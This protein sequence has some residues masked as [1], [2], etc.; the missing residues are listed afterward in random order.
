MAINPKYAQYKIVTKSG[1]TYVGIL[2]NQSSNSVSIRMPF[3]I[4]MNVN[5]D[6]IAQ[7]QSMRYSI[8]PAGLEKS[9]TPDGLRD[10]IEF[11]RLPAAKKSQPFLN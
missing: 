10:L 5:R 7:L 2:S 11:I 1:D 4:S 9:L 8:M 3:S 6:N